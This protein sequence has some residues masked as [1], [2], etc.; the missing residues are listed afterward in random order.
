M[1]IRDRAH[2]ALSKL[3]SEPVLLF[4]GDQGRV[5][6]IRPPRFLKRLK[7]ARHLPLF[8]FLMSPYPSDPGGN[9]ALASLARMMI[10]ELG[11]LA[12][13]VMTGTMSTDTNE[14][15]A[16]ALSRQLRTHGEIDRAF[17]EAC[18]EV[19]HRPDFVPPALYSRLREAPLFYCQVATAS[20]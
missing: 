13:V 11:I 1:C 2:A 17:G 8:V 15:F 9:E 5:D 19:S 14:L 16:K 20:G 10:E 6:P 7:A 18:V 4:E 3:E 12:A